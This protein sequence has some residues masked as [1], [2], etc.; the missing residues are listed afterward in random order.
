MFKYTRI[1]TDKDGHSRFEEGKVKLDDAGDIGFLSGR[2]P[3]RELVFRTV[4]PGYD[5]DFHNAPQRQFI[6]LLD[7]EIE[8]ETSLG[9][10][11]IFKGGDVLLAEDT[12]GKGH[13]TRNLQNAE[14]RSA[15]LIL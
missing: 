3:V 13:K 9:E 8:I 5:Y 2:I 14:R 12:E 4:K 15:F 10:K 6:F 11:R 1:Y 7:G